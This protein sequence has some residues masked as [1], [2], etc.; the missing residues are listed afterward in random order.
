MANRI[1]KRVLLVGWDAADWQ[2]IRPL[3]RAGKLPALARLMERGVS[4]N[5]ATIQPMLSP[6][7]WNSIAT[8]KRADKH[9]ICGFLEPNPDR[10]GVRPVS[11]TSRKCKAVWNILTQSGLTSNVVSWYASHP[12]EP[13]RGS[14]VTDRF[15][16]EVNEGETR[17]S[18]PNAFHPGSLQPL[19]EP[20][21]VKP[22]DI[23]VDA[24]LPFVPR[25]AEID[26]DSDDRLVK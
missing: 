21:L 26:Q 16:A 12:A 6:M 13:I 1:A 17:N 8:G 20:L 7:L 22:K 23:D 10:S 5:L 19:M 24:L 15:V 9:G 11:S 3:L 4:G 18:P 2:M 14:I 25:A